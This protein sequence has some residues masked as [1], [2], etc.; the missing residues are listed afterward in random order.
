MS[1]TSRQGC[2]ANSP[3]RQ[4][5]NTPTRQHAS[6]SKFRERVLLFLFCFLLMLAGTSTGW[7]QGAVCPGP[8]YIPATTT[9]VVQ[10][11]CN[12]NPITSALIVDYGYPAPGSGILPATQFKICRV[13]PDPMLS[14]STFSMTA[15]EMREVGRQLVRTNPAGFPCAP[16][17]PPG[18][19]ARPDC[20]CA[21]ASPEWRVSWTQC[22]K[23]EAGLNGP[24]MVGCETT[25]ETYC[26]D[27]YHI[28]C[29]N[30]SIQEYLVGSNGSQVDCTWGVKN[31]QDIGQ[32]NSMC[33]GPAQPPPGDCNGKIKT[34]DPGLS[35]ISPKQSPVQSSTT[36][37]SVPNVITQQK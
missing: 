27:L 1:L 10:F 34:D 9:I 32:C 20:P 3:T 7:S 18:C 6:R 25:Q 11:L 24:Q 35:E 33:A 2:C 21:V 14:C 28:C 15:I 22:W 12:G 17:C 4:L 30:G 13:R 36:T 8:G 5:A 37:T 19:A 26:A 31:P 23:V 29:N 16:I